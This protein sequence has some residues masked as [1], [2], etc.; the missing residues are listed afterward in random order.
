MPPACGL[1]PHPGL[2]GLAAVFADISTVDN[3][4]KWHI[5]HSDESA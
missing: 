2:L 1:P 5:C 3:P 4:K